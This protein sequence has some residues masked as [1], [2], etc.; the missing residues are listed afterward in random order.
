MKDSRDLSP[1]TCAPPFAN[2]GPSPVRSGT[3]HQGPLRP[4]AVEIIHGPCEPHLRTLATGSVQAVITSPP[5]NM[6]REY[7]ANTSLHSY[8][9]WLAGVV[10]QLGRVVALHGSVWL[11]VGN[12]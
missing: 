3:E 7:E 4:S 5:Y 12:Y 10:E 6:G 11:Q 1:S 8:V 9:S 2:Q